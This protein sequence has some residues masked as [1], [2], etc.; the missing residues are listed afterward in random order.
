VPSPFCCHDVDRP[1]S[2]YCMWFD[3]GV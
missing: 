1:R 2:H 3:F